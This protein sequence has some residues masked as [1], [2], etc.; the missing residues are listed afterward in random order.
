[1]AAEQAFIEAEAAVAILEGGEEEIAQA[2]SALDFQQDEVDRLADRQDKHTIKAPYSGYVTMEYT[3]VGHWIKQG[4][5]A[6]MLIDLEHVYVEAAV[7]ESYVP[8]VSLGDEVRVSIEALPDDLLTGPVEL[9]VPQADDR[10]RSFPVKVRLDNR[11]VG[12]SP[13][14][15][16][17]MFARVSLPVGEP[18]TSLLVPKDAVVLGGERPLVYVVTAAEG[19]ADRGTARPVPVTLGVSVEN[20]ITVRGELA[21]GDQVVVAGNE[22]LNPRTP[23][24]EVAIVKQRAAPASAAAPPG[25]S[26]S[27]QP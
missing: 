6:V 3:E 1:V 17:G 8:F 26:A 2:Q 9:I 5:P 10:S 12:G 22:R 4:D 19:A 20:L 15:K 11:V 27:A 13:R 23:E 7:L 25:E 18:E 24:Q 16:P 14:L 21:A